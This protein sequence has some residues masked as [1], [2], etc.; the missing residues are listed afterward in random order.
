MIT[1]EMIQA[2]KKQ[3]IHRE[4]EE[5]KNKVQ[6]D[7]ILESKVHSEKSFLPVKKE[8]KEDPELA[9]KKRIATAIKDI[10]RTDKAEKEKQKQ[11]KEKMELKVKY[12][13]SIRKWKKNKD[14]KK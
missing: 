13:V 12:K 8:V 4:K 3:L 10:I 6:K 11:N 9:H 14:R 1:K 7:N 5:L 2:K